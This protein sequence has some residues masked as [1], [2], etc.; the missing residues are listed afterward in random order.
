MY[1]AHQCWG[2]LRGA[3]DN[4]DAETLQSALL[5]PP[6]GGT[7]DLPPKPQGQMLWGRTW[8]SPAPAR[9]QHTPTTGLRGPY[10]VTWLLPFSLGGGCFSRESCPRLFC[11]EGA[12]GWKFSRWRRW[13]PD[14]DMLRPRPA[15]LRLLAREREALRTAVRLD[16]GRTTRS[17]L[18]LAKPRKGYRSPESVHVGVST[19]NR[20][21]IWD[22]VCSSGNTCV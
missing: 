20:A 2:G 22:R 15:P 7:G 17:L 21:F 4:R 19:E 8:G 13:R 18:L 3:G 6:P 12:K 16:P 14:Q 11:Q 5:S 1:P 10:H 9:G